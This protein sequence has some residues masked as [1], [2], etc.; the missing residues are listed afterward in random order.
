MVDM[1]AGDVKTND[2][3]LQSCCGGETML[4]MTGHWG[5]AVSTPRG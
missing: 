2:I 4:L 3:A 1:N 5:G